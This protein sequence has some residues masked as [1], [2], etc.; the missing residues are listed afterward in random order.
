MFCNVDN[1]LKKKKKKGNRATYPLLFGFSG[2]M[3]KK[4]IAFPKKK[5]HSGIKFRFALVKMKSAEIKRCFAFMK[6][7][8]E[9]ISHFFALI[10]STDC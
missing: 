9:N 5:K 7:L 2:A 10:G 4:V 6:N 8:C 3:K 1:D